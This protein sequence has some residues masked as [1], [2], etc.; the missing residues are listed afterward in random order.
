MALPAGPSRAV[1]QPGTDAL[2]RARG[3][4]PEPEEQLLGIERDTLEQ[5]EDKRRIQAE[6]A[7]LRR[8]FLVGMM[9][10]PMF[11]EWLMDQLI[12]FDTFIHPIAVS[13]AGFPDPLATQYQMG[14]K[15][16]GWHL[17][18]AFDDVA[19]EWTSLMRRERFP[20]A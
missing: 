13:P 5:E 17:W 16:A 3:E 1:S 10:N 15:A 4:L 19:P 14:M 7:E 20:I 6:N 8:L 2:T 12:F 11:R 18:T 9:Q